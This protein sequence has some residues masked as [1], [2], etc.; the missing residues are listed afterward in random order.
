[1]AVVPEL[2]VGEIAQAEAGGLGAGQGTAVAQPFAGEHAG[3][4][5]PDLL[6]LAE[7][8]TDLPGAHADIA[9]GHVGVRADVALELGHK[10]LAEPHDLGVA[11]ALG[12]EVGAA[13]AAA[14]GQGGEGVFE[15]LLKAQKLDDGQVDGG[16]EAQAALVGADG[17]VKLHPVAPVHLDLAA[18]VHPGHP[19]HHNALRLHHAADDILLLIAGVGLH[20][21]LQ[22][23]QHLL[24]SLEKL[25]LVGA[26]G[27]QIVQHGQ[28][29]GVF[30]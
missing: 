24:H 13:L 22:G 28:Q 5:V 16:M 23:L 6:V 11:L 26:F 15:N 27:F 18:V 17:G 30:H 9:S 4:L 20:N 14:H 19:E 2:G 10:G 8:E 21:G 1:M 29:I 12:V 25:G 7:E 3:E